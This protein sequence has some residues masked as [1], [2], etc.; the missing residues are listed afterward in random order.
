[1][2]Q[3]PQSCLRTCEEIGPEQPQQPTIE[4]PYWLI[5]F[6]LYFDHVTAINTLLISQ[7]KTALAVT[8]AFPLLVGIYNI[9]LHPLAG[10]ASICFQ[11]LIMA[12]IAPSARIG[13]S[14]SQKAS[15]KKVAT[16]CA[17]KRI[18]SQPESVTH[19]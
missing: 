13:T 17:V 3:I 12:D 1:M 15:I 11:R 4:P 18:V 6:W 10:S 7:W 9:T 5:R 19:G 16:C 14:T 8:V 2:G